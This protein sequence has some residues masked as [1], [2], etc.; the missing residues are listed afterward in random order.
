M[1]HWQKSCISGSIAGFFLYWL[2]I[3]ASD[4]DFFKLSLNVLVVVYYAMVLIGIVTVIVTLIYNKPTIP[5]VLLRVLSMRIVFW[6]VFI[7][8]GFCGTLPYLRSLF[9]LPPSEDASG[10]LLLYYHVIIVLTWTITLGVM[11]IKTLIQKRRK[12][13]T[14]DTLP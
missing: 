2:E 9:G 3:I 10:L 13:T 6:V 1:K 5:C 12:S 4:L 7:L 11:A 14:E 8:N